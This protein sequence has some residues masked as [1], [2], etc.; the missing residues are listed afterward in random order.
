[1]PNL[2]TL[3]TNSVCLIGWKSYLEKIFFYFF[4]KKNIFFLFS[5]L[6]NLMSIGDFEAVD[7]RNGTMRQHS[8][9]LKKT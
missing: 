7:I 9:F 4:E 6:L 1:M 5:S 3:N 2:V 8:T